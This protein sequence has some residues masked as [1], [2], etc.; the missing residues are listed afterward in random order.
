ML[1]WLPVATAAPRID[2]LS[3]NT[4]CSGVLVC[5]AI[6]K[7]Q[8]LGK[9]LHKL[10]R[11]YPWTTAVEVQTHYGVRTPMR[12]LNLNVIL[13]STRQALDL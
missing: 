6:K 4:L 11:L 9:N 2:K 13:H 8:R 3:M 10:H 12:F 1:R 7:R 5:R